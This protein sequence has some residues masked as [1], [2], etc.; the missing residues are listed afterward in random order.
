MSPSIEASLLLAAELLLQP[1]VI[2]DVPMLGELPVLNAPDIDGPQREAPP[3]RGDPQQGLRVRCG[4]GHACDDLVAGD[5]PVLDPCLD[6][7][8]TAKDRAKILD[9][10]GEAAGAPTGVLDV[11]LGV[12]L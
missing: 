9:L 2:D 5:D 7:R 12:D 1:L 8:H 4:E 6:V 3:S 11:G 10:S